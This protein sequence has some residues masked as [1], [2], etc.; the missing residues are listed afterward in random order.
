MKQKVKGKFLSVPS[1]IPLSILN[2]G[3]F[4]NGENWLSY[5]QS[6]AQFADA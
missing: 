6:M 4:Y 1:P 2:E 3:T 5:P